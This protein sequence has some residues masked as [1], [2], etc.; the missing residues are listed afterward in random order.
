[1]HDQLEAIA[2][3]IASQIYLINIVLDYLNELTGVP[4]VWPAGHLWP[5]RGSKMAREV[6][7]IFT[8]IL[9][10]LRSNDLRDKEKG[11]GILLNH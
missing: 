10:F 2:V 1:M 9:S 6:I 3:C 8:N 4:K 7:L 5:S 11:L